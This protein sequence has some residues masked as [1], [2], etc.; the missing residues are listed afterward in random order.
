MITQLVKE[1]AGLVVHL[2][3]DI[4]IALDQSTQISGYSIYKDK[5]LIDYGHLSPS[6]DYLTRIVKLTKW[7]RV[8]IEN[9]FGDKITV[10]L[11][12]IQLQQTPDSKG[13]MNVE[14]FKKLAH[15]QGALLEYL[16][17]NKINYSIIPS[18]T[19][20]SKCKIK[21]RGR[22]EQKKN[23]QLYVEKEFGIKATQDEADAICIGK[24]YVLNLENS[25]DWS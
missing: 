15:C 16:V 12:E 22:A 8:Q 6:G 3:A 25:F 2:M 5:Q 4:I 14:T 23:A 21:G 18:V 10:L 24:S 13:L 19:W 1:L 11:E 20:K 7:L 17:E 9:Y